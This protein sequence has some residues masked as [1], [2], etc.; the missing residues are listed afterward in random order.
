[1]KYTLHE[2]LSEKN[3]VISNLHGFIN[4]NLDT[5]FKTKWSGYWS[6]PYKFLDYYAIKINGIWL[7]ESTLKGVEYGETVT[8]Y[9]ETD[10]L[11]IKEEVKTPEGFPGFKID[12]QLKNTTGD[13]KAVQTVIESGIDIRKRTE[14]LGSKNYDFNIEEGLLTV[15]N[16]SGQLYI[17]SNDDPEFQ[18]KKYT[19]THFPDGEKQT[20]FLP[21]EIAFRKE[22]GSGET[23][24]ISLEFRTSEKDVEKLEKID[25][26][27]EKK[28][29]RT[30]NSSIESMTNLAYSKESTGI[31]AGHPWFQNYWARDSFWTALG[32]IDAGYFELAEDVLETFA[33]NDLAG[34]VKTDGSAEHVK[35]A[36][37]EPLFII[38][39]DKLQRHYRLSKKLEQAQEKAINQLELEENIVKH[40]KDGTW[41]DTLERGPA[42]D[43]QSLWLEAA[44][45]MDDERIEKLEKGLKEFQDGE[46]LKDE[47]G[48]G[49]DAVNT[50]IPLMFKQVG[51]DTAESQL[52]KIN[53]EFSSRYGARTRSATDLGY[54]SEG[55]HTGSCWG[56]TTCW[57]A[58]ANL[59]YGNHSHGISFLEKLEQFLDKDQP[60][61][62]PEV[63][64]AETGELLGCSE[65]AWSAGLFVHTVDSYLLGIKVEENYVKI[66]PAPKLNMVRKGKKIRGETLDLKVEDGE[67]TVLN[68]P[69]LELRL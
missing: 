28:F 25:Q 50:V 9:H 3:A 1:M 67:A 6:P 27:L 33:E 43:I 60:G 63:V 65:Q 37:T 53:G 7:N 48:D 16:S 22:V 10:T 26:R 68:N 2:N 31:I 35:R 40:Q 49:A 32:L 5:G 54:D 46:T 30:F 42:V 57:A 69:D 59:S 62:L 11:E 12:I 29:S 36:D 21:G 44:K 18:G 34:K 19:R 58:M 17:Q 38:A 39:S 20:C 66:D 23:Q 24:D 14:D 45:I 8:Y 15:S 41:M 47:L 4:R 13:K 61:A 64:N 52:Q 56:L 51:T 55:Y